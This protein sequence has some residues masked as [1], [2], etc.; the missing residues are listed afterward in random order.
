MTQKF[1]TNMI[2]SGKHYFG[3]IEY[4]TKNFR[5]VI[6]AEIDEETLSTNWSLYRVRRPDF[7]KGFTSYM[8]YVE[9]VSEFF[10]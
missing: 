1:I 4:T 8:D 10:H 7:A 5:Y 9:D 3:E 6:C 2:A